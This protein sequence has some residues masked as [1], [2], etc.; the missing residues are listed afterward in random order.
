MNTFHSRQTDCDRHACKNENTGTLNFTSQIAPSIAQSG[1]RSVSKP[2]QQF[3]SHGAV[4]RFCATALIGCKPY[5][6]ARLRFHDSPMARRN[7]CGVPQ[8]GRATSAMQPARHPARCLASQS[9]NVRATGRQPP[10]HCRRM[11]G[12][13]TRKITCVTPMSDAQRPCRKL[14]RQ[15]AICSRNG[16]ATAVQQSTQ[17]PASNSWDSR[18]QLSTVTSKN[19]EYANHTTT[20]SRS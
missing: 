6:L 4:A 14:A 5:P 12:E 9:R 8:D 7:L 18:P 15:P 17:H 19:Y 3:S 2:M 10:T 20:D 16:G 13:T 1:T 11:T